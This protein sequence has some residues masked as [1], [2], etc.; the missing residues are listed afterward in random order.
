MTAARRIRLRD[1]ETL[2]VRHGSNQGG[3]PIILV[4][5][6]G[7][8]HRMWN[9]VA[10]SLSADHELLAYD[11][12]LHGAA[13]SAPIGSLKDYVR[14]L[15][16]IMD[17]HEIE[18]VHLAGVSMGGAIS[19]SFAAEHPS[20]LKS[21]SLICSPARSAGAF[22]ERALAAEREGI[23]AQIDS[24]LQRWFDEDA[25]KRADAAVIYARGQIISTT[26]ARWAASWR[27]LAQFDPRPLPTS[28]PVTLI[29]GSEDRSTPPT[30]MQDLLRIAPHAQFHVIEKGSHLLALERPVELA[31]LI[32]RSIASS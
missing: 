32:E 20:R 15:L 30:H 1:H 23:A 19:A 3:F 11:T 9:G 21:L 2:T 5:A 4:H 27:A 29:A 10:S 14:D 16:E 26:V 25:T 7:L 8:D 22:E 6:L 12:R 28:L 17:I 18:Q 13:A 31:A 24:T